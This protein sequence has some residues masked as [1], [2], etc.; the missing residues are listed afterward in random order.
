MVASQSRNLQT[1]VKKRQQIPTESFPTLSVTSSLAFTLPHCQLHSLPPSLPQTLPSSLT[2]SLPPCLPHYLPSSLPHS[3]PLSFLPASSL[4]LFCLCVCVSQVCKEAKA[5]LVFL[6]DG[7]WSIGDD[8]FL[9]ITRFLAS[10]VGSLD[11]IGADGTQV[12][13]MITKDRAT[14]TKDHRPFCATTLILCRSSNMHLRERMEGDMTSDLCHHSTLQ[15]FKFK[16][17]SLP[18]CSLSDFLSPSSS[19]CFHYPSIL[20][21]TSLPPSSPSPPHPLSL[22]ASIPPFHTPSLYTYSLCP[23]L[24]HLSI[25]QYQPPSL[26]PFFVC[27]QNYD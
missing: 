9:K 24:T 13:Q 26:P 6:V 12:G 21:P 8:N 27:T 7:S 10:T 19:P 3:L 14:I 18:P 5:E 17:D 1:S 4:F 16:I 2:P 15:L 11:L 22:L 20:L 25:P 23:S